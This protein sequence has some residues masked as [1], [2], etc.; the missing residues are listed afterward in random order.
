[1]CVN[2][3]LVWLVPKGSCCW[4]FQLPGDVETCSGCFLCLVAVV[5]PN[6]WNLI[7]LSS[8]FPLWQ[9]WQWMSHLNLIAAKWLKHYRCILAPGCTLN[10]ISVA[11]QIVPRIHL[12]FQ[13]RALK[14]WKEN[15]VEP[16]PPQERINLHPF[17]CLVTDPGLRSREESLQGCSQQKIDHFFWKSLFP[18]PSLQTGQQGFSFPPH[19]VSDFA[20]GLALE[21]MVFSHIHPRSRRKYFT[22]CFH[23]FHSQSQQLEFYVDYWII[24]VLD[25]SGSVCQAAQHTLFC[26]AYLKVLAPV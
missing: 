26:F 15:R 13:A 25:K 17:L 3:S 21:E 4:G 16:A 6:S 18:F 20:P 24:L 1:M 7:A 19:F 23:A 12:G 14:Y 11:P 2:L 8:R 22:L 5:Q 9:C 10:K